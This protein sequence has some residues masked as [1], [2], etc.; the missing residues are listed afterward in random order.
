MFELLLSAV[1]LQKHHQA[2][3][4]EKGVFA[5]WDSFEERENGTT[6]SFN[7]LVT[8]AGR[9]SEDVDTLWQGRDLS[10]CCLSPIVSTTCHS[11]SC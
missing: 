11:R 4:I 1:C 10:I 5:V 2:E 9:E 3:F 7:Y 6:L 8:D